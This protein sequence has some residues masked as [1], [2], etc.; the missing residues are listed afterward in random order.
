MPVEELLFSGDTT[1]Q[2]RVK[3]NDAYTRDCLWTGR[4]ENSLSLDNTKNIIANT[5][6]TNTIYTLYTGSNQ[7]INYSSILAGQSNS[8]FRTNTAG[9]D[10]LNNSIVGGSVNSIMGAGGSDFVKNS[11]IVGGKELA[12][13]K[14]E[15]VAILGGRSFTATTSLSNDNT[16]YAENLFTSGGR[17]RNYRNMVMSNN[18]YTS[19]GA[20]DYV[21]EPDDDI[22]NIAMAYTTLPPV[23]PPTTWN[24]DIGN[25][26][27]GTDDIGRVVEIVVAKAFPAAKQV[28]IG[29]SSFSTYTI[30]GVGG[31]PALAICTNDWESAIITKVGQYELKIAGTG[32]P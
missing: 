2:G 6:G 20:H 23:P 1:E 13:H 25:I 10:L 32:A 22:I 15:N 27:G 26:I 5:G 21:I 14:G 24:L 4:T 9:T 16:C 3:I 19:G 12:I 30:N 11:V 17:T 18:T 28:I 31:S 8:I 7:Q 29:A